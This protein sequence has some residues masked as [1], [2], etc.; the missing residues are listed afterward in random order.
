MNNAYAMIAQSI[1]RDLQ[2]LEV[3]TLGL[4]SCKRGREHDRLEMDRYRC[5]LRIATNKTVLWEVRSEPRLPGQVERAV[6]FSDEHPE[7]R[8]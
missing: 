2:R 3:L 1:L 4:R 8:R 5:K 6:R 7:E